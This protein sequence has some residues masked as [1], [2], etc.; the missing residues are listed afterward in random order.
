MRVKL[1]QIQNKHTCPESRGTGLLQTLLFD[2]EACT[3]EEARRQSEAQTLYVIGGHPL[4]PART[5]RRRRRTRH[6]PHNQTLT[7]LF[8]WWYGSQT[9]PHWDLTTEKAIYQKSQCR[10]FVWWV[11]LSQTTLSLVPWIGIS[12]VNSNSNSNCN[13]NCVQ[14][15]KSYINKKRYDKNLILQCDQCQR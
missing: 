15:D 3:D 13:C 2:N 14:T 6:V 7:L 10:D 12:F 4:A 8:L 5:R 11:Q 1:D 9:Q